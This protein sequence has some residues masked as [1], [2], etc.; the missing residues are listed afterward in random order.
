MQEQVTIGSRLRTLRKWR[1][2]S[3]AALAG[4][5]GISASFLSM[6]ERGQRA[7]D[8]RSYISA[9]AT[10][11]R[12]SETELTGGPHL[13][14]DPVQSGPH[15][16][17]PALRTSLLTNSPRGDPIAESAR[18][19]N[20]LA[21]L[22][23]GTVE[24][25][26]RRY[27]YIE[28]G[29]HLPALIDEAHV[30]VHIGG[31]QAVRPALEVLLEA[32]MC[33]AGMA[34]TLGHPDL[35]HVAATRAD[36]VAVRL[37]DPVSRGKA[38]FAL[39][40]PDVVDRSRIKALADRAADRLEPHVHGDQR[41]MQALGML[42]LNAA[43]ASAACLDGTAARQWLDEAARI[44]AHVPDDMNASW[45]AFCA[46]NVAVWRVAVGVEHGEAGGQVAR[47]AAEVDETK[48]A[49]HPARRACF[50]TDVGRGL[51]R[52]AK[53]R[54]EAVTW[55]RRA[56]TLAPQRVRNSA[57]VRETVAVLLEQTRTAAQGRELRG[58]AARMGVPH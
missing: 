27:D 47:M 23:T 12:V 8:R 14:T 22:M 42:T 46:T 26:R 13:G 58:L 51:A 25:C 11:L 21:V 1:G 17:I 4:Q 20:E 9:L 33:A 48:L 56:E 32:Y 31:E 3:L 40:R 53:T 57:A 37:G 10:A 45:Q 29:K 44:A 55:L 5:A 49:V 36:E 24:R 28:V 38:A 2:L 41:G 6:A 15:A 43:L 35:A 7:L 50:Y 54:A 16:Y 39:F 18:P 34:R 52:D 30:H 19:V